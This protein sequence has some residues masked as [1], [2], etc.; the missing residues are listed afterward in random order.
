MNHYNSD[1]I[2]KSTAKI[3]AP[4]QDATPATESTNKL[5]QKHAQELNSSACSDAAQ[6]SVERVPYFFCQTSSGLGGSLESDEKY[7]GF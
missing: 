7:Q 6:M 5:W 1:Y 3:V 2:A 4:R